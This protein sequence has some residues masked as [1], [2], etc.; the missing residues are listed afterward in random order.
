M[1][2]KV[3]CESRWGNTAGAL[4][5]YQLVATFL[6][7]M[8]FNLIRSAL[9]WIQVPLFLFANL[10]IFVLILIQENAEENFD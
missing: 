9:N 3:V 2:T 1:T 5:E 8:N 6:A 7:T 10:Y 4:F